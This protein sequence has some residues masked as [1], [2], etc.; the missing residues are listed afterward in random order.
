MCVCGNRN[1]ELGDLLF[2]CTVVHAGVDDFVARCGF[3][4]ISACVDG[5]LANLHI[6]LHG[7]PNLAVPY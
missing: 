7:G 5:P 1:Y 4:A 6:G 3:V 2:D